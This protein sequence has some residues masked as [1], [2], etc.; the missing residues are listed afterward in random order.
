MLELTPALLEAIT[1]VLNNGR[2]GNEWSYCH[3]L[4]ELHDRLDYLNPLMKELS[5]LEI[6][7]EDLSKELYDEYIRITGMIY[8]YA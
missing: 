1:V 2:K 5:K 7:L 8:M 4:R 6:S 3:A